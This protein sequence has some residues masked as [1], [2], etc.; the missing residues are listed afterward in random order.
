MP[1]QIKNASVCVLVALR[2]AESTEQRVCY[3]FC[4]NIGKTGAETKDIIKCHLEGI[5]LAVFQVF[6]WFRCLK[7][8]QTSVEREECPGRAG[9]LR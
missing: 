3:K 9:T 1:L 6:G 5:P 8:A 4:Q 2:T 7:E